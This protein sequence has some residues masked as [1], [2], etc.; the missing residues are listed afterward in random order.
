MVDR[1]ASPARNSVPPTQWLDEPFVHCQRSDHTPTTGEWLVHKPI[2]RVGKSK[3]NGPET[4]R[5]VSE[6]HGRNSEWCAH[7]D[8][9]SDGV[10]SRF[11]DSPSERQATQQAELHRDLMNLQHNEGVAHWRYV[12]P[13]HVEIK[14]PKHPEKTA[15]IERNYW[16]KMRHTCTIFARSGKRGI[17]IQG[18]DPLT[19]E[20]ISCRTVKRHHL[21]VAAQIPIYEMDGDSLH[22]CLNNLRVRMPLDKDWVGADKLGVYKVWAKPEY[23]YDELVWVVRGYKYFIIPNGADPNEVPEYVKDSLYTEIKICRNNGY[24]F[25]KNKWYDPH[26]PL[27]EGEKQ[28]FDAEAHVPE[29]MQDASDRV[30]F[31]W[32]RIRTPRY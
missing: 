15:I 6:H 20:P 26:R 27:R 13:Q 19:E 18:T 23:V 3:V 32:L 2:G 12:R 22:L 30:V 24:L 29:D 7:F 14:F 28:M 9:F 11:P 8:Y 21:G 16:E 31:L 10:A 1:D 17:S 4:M 25:W 5:I